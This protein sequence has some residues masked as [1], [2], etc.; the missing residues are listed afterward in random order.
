MSSLGSL[1]FNKHSQET[2]GKESINA[3]K[4]TKDAGLFFENFNCQTKKY[5]TFFEFQE[6]FT[7]D[8]YFLMKSKLN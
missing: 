5:M 8:I 1:R 7:I 2:V 4:Q 6:Q 3:R